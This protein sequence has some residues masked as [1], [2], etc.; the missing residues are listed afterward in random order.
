MNIF[1]YIVKLFKS[2]F[3]F[4]SFDYYVAMSKED[5]MELMEDEMKEAAECRVS[6][7]VSKILDGFGE[8]E[9]P[10]DYREK[11]IDA[12]NALSQPERVIYVIS[13]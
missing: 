2:K 13:D 9:D 1:K 4:K 12:I 5:F 11:L 8:I 10:K 3:S 6:H 7:K